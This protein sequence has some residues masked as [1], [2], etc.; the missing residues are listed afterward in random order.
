MHAY[1]RMIHTYIHTYIHAY[2]YIHIYIAASSHHRVRRPEL[3]NG[4]YFRK[5]DLLLHHEG[6]SQWNISA[7]GQ[8]EVHEHDSASISAQILK[9]FSKTRSTFN[10]F[11]HHIG[12]RSQKYSMVTS[13]FR[14]NRTLTFE[15]LWQARGAGRQRPDAARSQQGETVFELRLCGGRLSFFSGF[16]LPLKLRLFWH[17]ATTLCSFRI[18]AD[19]L[20][21]SVCGSKTG[22]TVRSIV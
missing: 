10:R 8:Q 13:Y 11:R 2:A 18:F 12:P 3:Q 1:I 22:M 9:S 20:P 14:F 6:Y 19:S 17:C 21:P 15:N 7:N 5:H 4:A 16:D